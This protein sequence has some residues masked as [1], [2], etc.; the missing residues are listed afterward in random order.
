MIRKTDD[1]EAGLCESSLALAL[2]GGR[3]SDDILASCT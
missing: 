2:R 3:M 1:E